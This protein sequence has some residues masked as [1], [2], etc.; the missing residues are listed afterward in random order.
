MA[1]LLTIAE[2]SYNNTVSATI[3]IMPFFALYGQH[4]RYTMKPRL[5]QKILAPEAL[6]EWAKELGKLKSYLYSEIKYSQAVQA[7]QADQHRLPAPMFQI[8]NEVWVLRRHIQTTRP[9]FKLDFK[10]LGRFKI[11]EKISS[12]AYKLYLP[13][14]MKCHP[15]FD[16]S[17]LEPTSSNPLKRQ[18]CPAPP[19]IVVY[20]EQEYEVEKLVDS[21]LLRKKLYYLVRWVGHDH[22]T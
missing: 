22:A 15:V 20:D 8:G 18:K 4:H 7:E 5:N 9:S 11:L 17:L 19:T 2:F 13:T 1:E 21:K 6:K 14:Y 16:V 10:R 3:G 12:H